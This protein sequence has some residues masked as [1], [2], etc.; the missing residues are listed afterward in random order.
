LATSF[1]DVQHAHAIEIVD[2]REVAAALAKRLLVHPDVG[3]RL[4]LEALQTATHGAFHDGVNFIPGKA[5]Q[6]GYVLS[7]DCAQPVDGEPLKQRCEAAGRTG[8][9]QLHRQRPVLGTITARRGGGQNRAALAGIEVTPA[10]LGLMIVQRALAATLSA[11]PGDA[12]FVFQVDVNFLLLSRQLDALDM[13]GAFDAENLGR[14]LSVLQGKPSAPILALQPPSQP[15]KI[16]KS[17]T[18]MRE[19]IVQAATKIDSDW[20]GNWNWACEIAPLSP[21]CHFGSDSANHRV[22]S[23]VFIYAGWKALKALRRSTPNG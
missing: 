18:M 23:D 16:R 14:E 2:Q 9:G 13:P 6:L 1:S 15:L 8:P 19:E 10:P 12:R 20:K 22:A 11:L 21:D 4:G 3:N 5:Q 7:Q 17:P